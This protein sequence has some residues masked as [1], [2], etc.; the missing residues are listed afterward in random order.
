[1][2]VAGHD[3]RSLHDVVLPEN[4]LQGGSQS[5]GEGRVVIDGAYGLDYLNGGFLLSPGSSRLGGDDT[6]DG[7]QQV[8][9]DL[10]SVGTYRE[11]QF[12]IVGNDVVLGPPMDG[13]NRD[14]GRV[15]W[16]VLAGNNG[17][18]AQ[19]G[20]CGDHNRVHGQLGSGSMTAFA[21]NRHIDRI[22]VGGSVSRCET[23]LAGG[24]QSGIVNRE[25]GVRLRK[26]RVQAVCEHGGR[27]FDAFLGGLAYE[28]EGPVPLVFVLREQHR[29]ADGDGHVQVVPAGVHHGNFDSLIVVGGDV[30]GVGQSSFF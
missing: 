9:A 14:N 30:A 7:A 27:A 4:R 10:I 16:I 12:H 19:N 24:G 17:L 22:S 11:L 21:E 2:V 13:A 8:L 5:L 29:R 3:G 28:Q 18:P 25:N 26:A 23:H 6:V 1:E 15:L 20:A